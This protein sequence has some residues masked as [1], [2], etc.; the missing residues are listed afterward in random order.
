M[1]MDPQRYYDAFS[2]GYDRRRHDGYHALLDQLE[3]ELV[4]AYCTDRH[5]LDAGC[6]T[7]LILQ[8]VQRELRSLVGVDLSGGMLSKA[9]QRSQASLVQASLTR[10]PFADASFDAAYSFKVLAHVPDIQAAV[11]ELGRVV[12]PGG[13][14]ILEF[15]NPLSVR[16][17]LW[18]L[19]RPGRVARGVRERDVFVRF[20]T[21]QR[22]QRYLP[23]AYKVVETRGIRVLTPFA[24]ALRLPG[25]GP[26]LADA[27]RLLASSPARVLGSFFV[28]VAQHRD[29]RECCDDGAAPPPTAH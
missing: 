27:E 18:Q 29:G 22:A 23:P 15:Y 6:G 13:H 28:V 21:P 20:D 12:R 4:L 11:K 19:K 2:E 16:G 17:L 26:L 3:S 24:Q 7:G 14:L 1:T 5:V 25:V 9:R 10:L 8:R